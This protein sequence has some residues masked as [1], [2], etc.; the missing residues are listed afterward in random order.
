MRDGIVY[1]R[2]H[3]EM[4]HHAP[5]HPSPVVPPPPPPPHHH[6]M[7][8]GGNNNNDMPCDLSCTGPHGLLH[9][10]NSNFHPDSLSPAGSAIHH[11]HSS[12][13][14]INLLPG[15][16]PHHHS[17]TESPLYSA[18]LRPFEYLGTSP[19]SGFFNNNG[20]NGG[21]LSTGSHHHHHHVQK[22]RPRKRKMTAAAAASAAAVPSSNANHSGDVHPAGS[23]TSVG[24]PPSHLG[25]RQLGSE[26]GKPVLPYRC[27]IKR[28]APLYSHTCINVMQ[29]STRLLCVMTG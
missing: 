3:Y 7:T 17:M 25:L 15:E 2:L 4:L 1:C 29:H 19:S 22:G 27:R 12:P 8:L 9:H 28:P 5:H 26:L 18:G 20:S 21:P 11:H 24:S 14:M 23:V 13:H 10:P 16:P 6:L